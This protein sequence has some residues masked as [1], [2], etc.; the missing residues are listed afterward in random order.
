MTGEMFQRRYNSILVVLLNIDGGVF[1][2][3]R[4]IACI[5]ALELSNNWIAGVPI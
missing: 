4:W 1:D 5:A 3:G 2:H